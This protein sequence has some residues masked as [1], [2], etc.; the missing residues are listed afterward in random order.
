MFAV[1][2]ERT[3]RNAKP[4]VTEPEQVVTRSITQVRADKRA[5]MQ[6]ARKAEIQAWR[7]KIAADQKRINEERDAML[8]VNAYA[9]IDVLKT[10][11]PAKDI[12]SRVAAMH[13]FTLAELAGDRRDRKLIE[14][15]FDAIKAV[16]DA[17]PDMSLIRIGKIFNRDHTSILH[18]LRKRGG[19]K[20][21]DQA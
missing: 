1:R 21:P 2:Y 6:A 9:G 13:G 7:D 14:A 15:R 16:A 10:V 11:T 19:R 4:K 12:A 8:A 17:R 20:G 3:M 18:A 5:E